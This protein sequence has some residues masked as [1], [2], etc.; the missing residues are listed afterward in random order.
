MPIETSN[1][2]ETDS[3]GTENGDDAVA[4]TNGNNAKQNLNRTRRKKRHVNKEEWEIFKQRL[5]RSKGGEYKG[6][7]IEDGKLS[8]NENKSARRLK[9]SCLC[10]QSQRK[11]KLYCSLVTKQQKEV[12]VWSKSWVEKKKKG[13]VRDEKMK[14]KNEKKF[15]FTMDLQAP[16]TNTSAK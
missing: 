16:L 7:S 3:E 10:V 15:V 9:P 8:F 4:T 5:K 14:D 6:L 13:H 2:S 12:I 11:S 1:E